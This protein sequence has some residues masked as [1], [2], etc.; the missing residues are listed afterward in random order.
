LSDGV[1][2]ASHRDVVRR[3]FERAAEAF[4]SRTE[5]RFDVLDPVGFSR[6]SPGRSVVEVGAGTGNFLGLF[7]EIAAQC[8]AVDVTEAMLRVAVARYSTLTPL[9]AD[10]A[11]L[12]L[13]SG[14][15]DLVASAQALHHVPRPVPFLAEMGRVAGATGR[16][17][18][19]DQVASERYEEAVAMNELDVLRDPS[20]AASRPPS[21]FR[22][23]L[24]AARLAPIDERIVAVEQRL[25]RW[26]WP[27]EFPQERIEAVRD[28]IA[29]RGAETGM[30]FVRDGDDWRFTR[31]RIMI[32]AAPVTAQEIGTEGRR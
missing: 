27:E 32:L 15:F 17:L 18:I 4:A 5:G 2:G 14:S 13:R 11:R 12:P 24:R 30:G 16:V 29:R 3:E 23:M 7:T 9:V 8:V 21:A 22:I 20:H 28:F 31:R 6:L 26:M 19:V 10:G 25:S 1:P